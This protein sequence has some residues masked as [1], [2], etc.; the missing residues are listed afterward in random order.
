MAELIRTRKARKPGW[1]RLAAWAARAAA[2][3]VI[4]GTI[5]GLGGCTRRYY[6]IQADKVAYSLIASKSTDPRWMIEPDYNVYPNL[7][8]RFAD[9]TNPDRPPM[10]PDDPGAFD[11]SPMP[12]K[13]G[14][15]GIGNFEG[16]GYLA[17]LEKWDAENRA[18]EE[19]D[20]EREKQ[21]GTG[22][23]KDDR[24]DKNAEA[25]SP[26][27]ATVEGARRERRE[28]LERTTRELPNAV[29]TSR[30]LPE[31]EA[32]ER[33]SKKRPFLIGLVNSVELGIINSREYQTRREE[34][35]LT[36]LPVSLE[37][38]AF[39][40]QVFNLEQ[41]FRERFGRESP[42]GYVNR[43]KFEN[44]LG[45]T[46]LFST[47]ALLTASW[48]N[49]TIYN[50][51]SDPST[52]VSTATLD[53]IQPFLRGGGKAV[54]LEPLTQAERNLVYALRDY[55]KWR[56]EFYAW[57]AAGQSTFIPGV[58]GG[59]L[60]ISP[61]TITQPTP[62]VP[63]STPVVTPVGPVPPIASPPQ[64][65]PGFAGRLFPI[66]QPFPNPQGFLSTLGEKAVL[67]NYYRNIQALQ[68]FLK[69]FR[70][71]V[72]GGIVNPVQVGQVE[73][74]LLQSTEFTLGRQV[75]YRSD[76]DE[77]KIQLGIPLCLSLDLE[78][79]ELE[80][81][82]SQTR[83]Y[84]ELSAESEETSV[85]ILRLSRV[86]VNQLRGRL[87]QLLPATPLTRDTRF[88]RRLLRD[89]R[90]WEEL[91]ARPGLADPIDLR[92][93]P[94]RAEQRKLLD[95]KAEAGGGEL[96]AAEQRR[97]DA[98]TAAIDLGEFEKILRAFERE[99]WSG[100]K[101]PTA[102]D[103]KRTAAFLNVHRAL[104]TVLEGAFKERQ[105]RI[106]ARWAELP[107]LCVN[108]VDLLSGPD[109]VVLAASVQ[110]AFENRL[111]LMNV[112]AQV[113]DSWRKIKVAANALMGVFNVEYNL[114]A[115]SPLNGTHPFAVGG[116]RT[117]H[118]LIFT[119]QL[120][121]VRMAERNNYRSALISFQQERR[122]LQYAEDNV[123]F[124]V[125]LELRQ[126]RASA[127]N[128]HV[129]QKRAIELA[130]RQVDLALAAFNQPAIPVGPA[131]PPGAV[132]APTTGAGAGDPAAL[133]QQLLSTQN[134]LLNAQNDLYNT[135]TGYLTTRTGFYRDLGIM[136]LDERGVW[137]DDIATCHCPPAEPKSDNDAGAE[138]PGQRPGKLPADELPA[139]RPV[140][141][142]APAQVGPGR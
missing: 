6:R 68:R 49:R 66:N 108:G 136:P 109:D 98:V 116:S 51:G 58:Q 73:Q 2:L 115:S 57:I 34:L 17:L 43:W 32:E 18:R 84:E 19:A 94:L 99:P 104:M 47:G 131:L 23:A 137:I 36:A 14:H 22:Q 140:P 142:A 138:R 50:L 38:F 87:R 25:G 63:L 64:V 96:P 7:L 85:Q 42:D 120:P 11:L 62:F 48:F 54:T 122:Q 133:T 139:P 102:R 20:A 72:E 77:F 126:L 110:A 130:Y 90:T 28:A 103:A 1:A 13:P 106:R 86:G 92:L 41:V 100:E 128:Y 67:V 30:A 35:Y 81:M 91:P 134:S 80:P 111:D 125:R 29:T 33:Y 40:P 89:W 21:T 10:P 117:Q 129:I 52:S 12:Q 53:F 3:T 15:A 132:G 45:F 82:L 141:A 118:R 69:L 114:T 44:T 70:V 46:Q 37:R 135:W 76:L 88:V 105:D 79:T 24:Q 4:P 119:G 93:R 107:A 127:F 31:K 95:R 59:V 39:C 26:A 27:T 55:C 123:A 71:Y 75:S 56:Q 74:Q 8:A 5:L 97:L 78:M 124:E 16:T 121:F 101:A 60:A 112:R 9:P 113:V 65:V 61:G 83:R